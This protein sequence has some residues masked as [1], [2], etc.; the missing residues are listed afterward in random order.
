MPTKNPLVEAGKTL[1]KR[2]ERHSADFF[3]A[4]QATYKIVM[5]EQPTPEEIAAFGRVSLTMGSMAGTLTDVSGLANAQ[6]L[7]D[8]Q[9][10]DGT[11]KAYPNTPRKAD[12]PI[13]DLGPEEDLSEILFENKGFSSGQKFPIDDLGPHGDYAEE[14]FKN[15]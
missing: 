12:V 7:G 11:G 1:K 8:M 10:S 4:N 14:I 6:G 3:L 9:F 2:A 15:K 5:G 13:R